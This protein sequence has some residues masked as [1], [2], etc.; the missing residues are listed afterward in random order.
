[1]G[2]ILS[3]AFAVGAKPGVLVVLGDADL[4]HN[5]SLPQ[6][7]ENAIFGVNLLDWLSQEDE[8]IALRTR[9]RRSRELRDFYQ[10]SIEIQGGMAGTDVENRV[11]DR[12][13]Q[14]ARISAQRTMAWSNI[15]FPP[16]LILLAAFGHFAV[17][18]SQSRVPFVRGEPR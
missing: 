14:K 12:R 3:G 13:A 6:G 8:L 1:L 17:R 16:L 4:F 15:F 7:S 2:T 11:I 5:R 10:E 9:G 18:R